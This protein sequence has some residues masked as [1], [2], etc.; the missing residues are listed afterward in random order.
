[1]GMFMPEPVGDDPENM[2]WSNK[3]SVSVGEM[4]AALANVPDDY[5]IVLESADVD[6]LNIAELNIIHLYP[7]TPQG[8]AGLVILGQGQVVSAEYDYENR[9]ETY[10]YYPDS[11]VKTWDEPA[12]EWR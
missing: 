12:K 6:D 1:M 11:G 4:K 10:L 3:W 2:K 5:E 9:H 7:P 8:N